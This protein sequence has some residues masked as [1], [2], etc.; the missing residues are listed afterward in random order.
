MKQDAYTGGN[1]LTM[2]GRKSL[3]TESELQTPV[4]RTCSRELAPLLICGSLV[5]KGSH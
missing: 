2:S 1:L 3:H 5:I 4:P